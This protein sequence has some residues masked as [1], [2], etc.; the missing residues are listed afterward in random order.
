MKCARNMKPGPSSYRSR[1]R[2]GVTPSPMS[3]SVTGSGYGVAG[4]RSVGIVDLPGGT[5]YETLE[6]IS[7]EQYTAMHSALLGLIRVAFERNRVLTPGPMSSNISNR[8]HLL[9]LTDTMSAIHH[10]RKTKTG[11]TLIVASNRCEFFS[12]IGKFR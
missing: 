11:F 4:G 5:E 3:G 12:A 6:G 9:P 7:R 8:K 1:T 2:D 10:I